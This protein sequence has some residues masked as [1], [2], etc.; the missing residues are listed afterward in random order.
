[1]RGLWRTIALMGEN[2]DNFNQTLDS[3]AS[4]QYQPALNSAL[5]L[6]NSPAAGSVD[7]R[8]QP[9]R[10]ALDKIDQFLRDY[11]LILCAYELSE[12]NRI[13]CEGRILNP[14]HADIINYWNGLGPDVHAHR[15]SIGFMEAVGALAADGYTRRSFALGNVSLTKWF[16]VTP[17]QE[18]LLRTAFAAGS[19][20]D[21]AAVNYASESWTTSCGLVVDPADPSWIH[22]NL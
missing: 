17:T 5:K 11:G 10:N 14:P 18:T 16:N 9:D 21:A 13:T 6:S 4:Q 19:D 20:S 15:H 2:A 22:V 1:M 3:L 8:P 12:V 7:L